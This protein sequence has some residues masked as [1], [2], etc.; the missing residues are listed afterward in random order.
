MSYTESLL[1]H[2]N[3]T[4][5]LDWQN[6]SFQVDC[7]KPTS[8]PF[9]KWM[10]R[11]QGRPYKRLKLAREQVLTW[12]RDD[13]SFNFSFERLQTLQAILFDKPMEFRKTAAFCR[14][15]KYIFFDELPDMFA[16]KLKQDCRNPCHPLARGI[17]LYLDIIHIHPFEDGN[18]R[19]AYLWLN[20]VLA[21]SGQPVPRFG[22]LAL[23]TTLPICK[24]NYRLL[25]EFCHTD[26]PFCHRG[27]HEITF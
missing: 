22:H 25:F 24:D 15:R 1:P 18:N 21:W 8:D 23:M 6:L 20:Y 19:A 12:A 4:L 3:S 9:I 13:E 26:K 2:L 27:R 16:R 10:D 5:E 14:T 17:R 11:Y 7:K